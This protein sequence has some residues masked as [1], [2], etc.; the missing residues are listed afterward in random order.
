M[1]LKAGLDALELEMYRK[2]NSGREPQK[3]LVTKTNRATEG[4]YLHDFDFY[5]CELHRE[6]N[7]GWLFRFEIS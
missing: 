2:N 1:G 3:V 5:I 6:L 4:R 7:G